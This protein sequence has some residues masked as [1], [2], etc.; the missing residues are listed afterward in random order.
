MGSLTDVGSPVEFDGAWKY[1]YSAPKRLERASFGGFRD[2]WVVV[3]SSSQAGYPS[4]FGSHQR[5][6]RLGWLYDDIR[7]SSDYVVA[8]QFLFLSVHLL[9]PFVPFVEDAFPLTH[10][11]FLYFFFGRH[12]PR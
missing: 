2:S 1:Q 7:P 10:R 9:S 6:D 12:Q 3:Q 11:P 8:F 5:P 4:E